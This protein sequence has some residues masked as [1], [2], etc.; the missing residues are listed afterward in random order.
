MFWI[1]GL[2]ME[3]LGYSLYLGHL[4]RKKERIPCFVG[5]ITMSST[6]LKIVGPSEGFSQK[7]YGG[8]GTLKLTQRELKVQRNPLPNHKGKE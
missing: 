5:F 2:E 1:N 6:L 4:L 3:L 7:A 8:G